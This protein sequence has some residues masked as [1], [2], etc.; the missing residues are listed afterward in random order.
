[1]RVTDI[2]PLHFEIPDDVA[3]GDEFTITARVRVT[4]VEEQICDATALNDPRT[5]VLG[6]YRTAKLVAM[7]AEK[8]DA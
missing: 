4:T 8:A 7:D 5:L 3:V 6:G 2:T 1:M